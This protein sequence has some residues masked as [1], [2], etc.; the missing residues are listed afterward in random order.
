MIIT[1][2]GSLKPS[3]LNSC[4]HVAG[5]SKVLEARWHLHCLADLVLVH[6]LHE[7]DTAVVILL[8]AGEV[9]FISLNSTF[10]E[11]GVVE[12]NIDQDSLC[13][14]HRLYGHVFVFSTHH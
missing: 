12:S 9:Q 8:K 6:V 2:I 11:V 1:Y 5:V 3:H 10:Q 7:P 13:F 14:L 4:V